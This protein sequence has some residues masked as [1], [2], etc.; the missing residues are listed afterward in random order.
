M[1]LVFYPFAF[2]RVCGSELADLEQ[3]L[4]ALRDRGA[5]VLV[6][7]VD[8]MYSQRVFAEREG[9]SYPML[10][11]FWPHGAVAKSYGVFDDQ[12]GVARRGT[13]LID[14]HG[15]VRWQMTTRMGE[16]RSV[17]AYFAALAQA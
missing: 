9:Y 3:N 4:V 2:T 11:D 15:L 16:A 10:A 5:E 1:L 17:A 8:S 6:V 13:F 14:H 7:S 12:A